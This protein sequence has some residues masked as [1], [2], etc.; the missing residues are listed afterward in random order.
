MK[1][2]YKGAAAGKVAATATLLA[3]ADATTANDKGP[4]FKDAS[5]KPVRTLTGLE[6]DASGLLKLPEL[7]ADDTTGTFVLR[8]TTTGGA[9]LT[10]ELT[11]TAPASSTPTPSDSP[12]PSQSPAASESPS[13]S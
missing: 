11:V 13:A 8:V 7:Y 2:T 4:Y 3:S 1:A 12:S 5:G 9:T 10:V 6:T